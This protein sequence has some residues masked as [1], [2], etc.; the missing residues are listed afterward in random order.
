MPMLMNIERLIITASL[1]GWSP[2]QTASHREKYFEI[3]RTPRVRWN[4]RGGGG[5]GTLDGFHFIREIFYPS[6]RFVCRLSLLKGYGDYISLSAT[7]SN[8]GFFFGQAENVWP[9]VLPVSIDLLN[10]FPPPSRCTKK[11]NWCWPYAARNTAI[12]FVLVFYDSWKWEEIF[13]GTK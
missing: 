9:G 12:F 3:K 2:R 1:I 5:E 6:V 10:P 8:S 7:I 13:E 11:A 4:V